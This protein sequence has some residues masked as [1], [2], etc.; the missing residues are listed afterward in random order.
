MA[1]VFHSQD[2]FDEASA[3][4]NQAKSHAVN[5]TYWLGCAI[6][7]QAR[8]WCGQ[9]RFEDA[10]SEGLLALE[11]FEKFSATKNVEK[12]RN[13]LQKVEQAIKTQSASF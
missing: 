2:K 3:H 13:L 11:I 10:K 7:L 9:R 8:V 12:C 6:Y 5:N 4:I 1:E